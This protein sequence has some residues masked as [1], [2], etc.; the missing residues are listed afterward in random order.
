MM[1][2]PACNSKK[3]RRFNPARYAQVYE[4]R[5]CGAIHGTLYLGD[6]YSLVLP[7]M[8]DKPVPPEKTRYFDFVTL[9]SKGI[10]RRHGWFDPE[11]RLVVQIG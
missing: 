8:T 1:F 4:C 2:C 5:T 9:G 7:Y 11:T 3:Q 10:D 6:S